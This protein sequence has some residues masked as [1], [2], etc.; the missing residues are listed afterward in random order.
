VRPF[1]PATLALEQ[2]GKTAESHVTRQQMPRLKFTH[3]LLDAVV[4]AS[5]PHN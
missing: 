4:A 5:T 3:T 1:I 2:F